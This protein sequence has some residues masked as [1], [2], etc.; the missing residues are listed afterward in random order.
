MSDERR[1]VIVGASLAGAKAAETLREE[2]FEGAIELVGEEA[3]LPYERPPLSKGVLLGKDDVS[4]SQLHDRDWYDD[5]RITLRLGTTATAVDTGVRRVELSDG[6]ELDYDK[7]LIAT[8]SRVRRLD[9]PGADLGGVRY[10]R[11]AAESV[12]LTEAFR[13]RPRV[14]VVGAG[15]I[16]LEATAAAREHGAEV[17][18]VEP[19]STALASVLG[20]RVGEI[21]ADLHRAHGVTMKFGTG[22]ESFSGADGR[23][24][25]VVTSAGETLPADLVVVGVGVLPNVELAAA[26]GLAVAEPEDGGGI[27]ADSSLRTSAPDVYAAG[28]V[29][30]WDHPVLGYPVRVEHWANA[31]DGGIAAAKAMLRED[32]VYD[33]IPFFYSDQYDTG[34][35]YSGHVPREASYEV[36]LRGDP[37]SGAWMAFYLGEGDR[38]LAGMHMNTWDTIDAVQDLIRSKAALD[39]SRLADPQVALADVAR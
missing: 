37:G 1:F 4:V 7:L 10:L 27:V 20:E 18:V 38:L 14:V 2:G 11:T 33:A 25:G 29:V 19:Q 32:A 22:V 3:E 21:Y 24:T 17:T 23:V 9:V 15:W 36:V 39:R 28:D 12:A 34:M 30:R 5:Q 35:E 26:A 8:G 16:G 6:T 31:Q 13:A